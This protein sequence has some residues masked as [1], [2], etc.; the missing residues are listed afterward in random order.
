MLT[1]DPH[2]GH[3]REKKLPQESMMI[4]KVG[5]REKLMISREGGGGGGGKETTIYEPRHTF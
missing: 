1:N 5:V 4:V 2:P 3:Q